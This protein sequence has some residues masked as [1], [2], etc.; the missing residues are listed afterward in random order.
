MKKAK[1]LKQVDKLFERLAKDKFH[2]P[3]SCTQLHQTRTY[4]F[5]LHKIIKLFERN[6]N[7]VPTSAR[8]L[9]YQYNLKQ[10][11]MLFEK[12]KEEYENI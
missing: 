1:A 12:Y 7:Y 5:E 4:I 3:Q 11:M 2:S 9:F 10:E 6:F 8:L